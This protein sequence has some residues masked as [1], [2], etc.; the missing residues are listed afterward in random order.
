MKRRELLGALGAGAAGLAVASTG[1]ALGQGPATEV[2]HRHDKT[3]EDCLKACSDCAKMCDETF[4]HCY[5]QVAEGKRDH[6]KPLHLVSDCAGFCSLS[7]CM[8]AKHSPL[9]AYSCGSCADACHATASEVEKFD[10][11]EMKAAAKSLRACEAS[12]RE[13]VKAMGGHDHHTSPAK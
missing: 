5:M 9:M 4:H 8:I 11:P 1:S 12:C 3:H 7:A 13:M 6:A 10:A 2:A